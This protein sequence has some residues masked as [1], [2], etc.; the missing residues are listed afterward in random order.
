MT[1]FLPIIIA[2]LT[3]SVLANTQNTQI[4]KSN[5]LDYFLYEVEQKALQEGVSQKTISQAFDGLKLNA[6]IIELDRKQP[7]FT[8]GFW[9][10]LNIGVNNVRLHHARKYYQKYKKKLQKN[11]FDYGVP[12]H[13]L[14]AIWGLETN[15]SQHTGSFN[16]IEALVTLA[17][18]KKRRT[19]FTGQLL[20]ALKLIDDGII[21][22]S[23]KSSWAGALGAMQFMPSNIA[24]Y[25]VD[26]NKNK[27]DLW[28]DLDDIF[29]S[30]AY[31]LKQ[32]GWHKGER[33]GRE[34][35]LPRTFDY[36]LARLHYKKPLAYWQ[37][38]GV[39]S[40]KNKDLPNSNL[41]GAII[42]PAGYK[43]PAFLV[44][45]NFEALMNWNR[46]IFYALT[47]GYLADKILNNEPLSV[48]PIPNIALKTQTIIHVQEKLN[49]LGFNAGLADGIIGTKTRAALRALQK[50]HK[51]PADGYIDEEL[52]KII[53]VLHTD[54][55]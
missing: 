6:R 20:S 8:V 33:W 7:E 29:A 55:R 37:T 31:F 27:L 38:L 52:L 22:L 42:L 46:S 4:D 50:K 24:T 9:Q 44:Y 1:K 2:I 41:L 18:D 48:A 36:E 21:P 51:L 25:S 13:I 40:T 3:T 34:V 12:P 16:L 53:D 10:Y 28:Y 5:S 17:F 35:K 11:Y 23:A 30:A 45:R 47:V 43:G 32:I 39:R 49:A 15:F 19:F 26:A 54:V 14:L